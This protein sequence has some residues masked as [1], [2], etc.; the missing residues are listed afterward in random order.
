MT[1]LQYF[2]LKLDTDCITRK[3]VLFPVKS[4]ALASFLFRRHVMWRC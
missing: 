2:N 1:T 4:V 3:G